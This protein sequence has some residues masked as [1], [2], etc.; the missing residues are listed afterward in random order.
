MQYNDD[1]TLDPQFCPGRKKNDINRLGL[2]D[3]ILQA[4]LALN[5]GMKQGKD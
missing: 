5:Y 1:A 3:N 2:I 4:N